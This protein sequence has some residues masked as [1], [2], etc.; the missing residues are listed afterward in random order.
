MCCSSSSEPL[1]SVPSKSI[2]RV[3]FAMTESGDVKTTSQE[4]TFDRALVADQTLWWTKGQR[5]AIRQAAM[6]DVAI[7]R[8][9]MCF[10]E[11][12]ESSFI[13]AVSQSYDYLR[14][15]EDVPQSIQAEF[16]VEIAMEHSLR[17]LEKFAVEEM[18]EDRVRRRKMV[19]ESVLY[20]QEKCDVDCVDVAMRTD[21]IRFASEAFSQGT[22]K[23]ARAYGEADEFAAR[24]E[25]RESATGEANNPMKIGPEGEKE[26]RLSTSTSS[27][28]GSGEV[29]IQEL[30]AVAA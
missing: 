8:G 6:M 7:A 11:Q 4:A 15:G 17:G 21:F 5:S 26:I 19:L 3:H 29:R 28:L 16:A 30:N 24:Y 14:Q 1:S 10:D 18:K 9:D 2:R 13:K 12:P 22:S 27:A 23:V 25:T 20:V